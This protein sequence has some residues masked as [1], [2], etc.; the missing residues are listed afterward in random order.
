MF[1]EEDVPPMIVDPTR[2]PPEQYGR[3][4]L[5][6]RIGK[7]GMAEVFRAYVDGFEGRDTFVVKRI[8]PEKSDSPELVEMFCNEARI[9]ALLH[10]PNIVEV[11]EFGQ[12]GGAYFMAM[13]YLRGR[14]LAAVMRALRLARG[15]VPPHLAAHIARSVALGLHH[16]HGAALGDGRPAE[17]VHRD[18]TPSNVMLLRAG[19][20]KVLD[21]GIAKAAESARAEGTKKARVRGKLAYLS[22]EQVRNGELDGRSDVFSL[23]VVLWEMLVGQRLFAGDN[24]FQTLRNVL[25]APVPPPSSRRADVPPALDA[26]VL[27]ALQRQ[28]EARY[29]TA[30]MMADALETTLEDVAAPELEEGVRRLL[31]DLFGA[32]AGVDVPERFTSSFTSQTM[33]SVDAAAAEPAVPLVVRP[34]A[35]RAVV[36]PGP[37]SP[38]ARRTGRAV[39]LIGGAVLAAILAWAAW[40]R[41]GVNRAEPDPSRRADTAS[42]G[43]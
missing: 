5:I 7:G 21:F 3:Y 30:L 2:P 31:S 14:D 42:A 22:P 11:Y 19:G 32:D 24:E 37:A 12:I 16:A 36:E 9:C 15:A 17:I 41:L 18:V 10:H 1:V 38:P 26:I 43:K 8:R 25:T 33:P 35:A 13:E 28:R 34:A 39:A 29:P 40:Q 4:R 23:G 20:V 6:D 27:R